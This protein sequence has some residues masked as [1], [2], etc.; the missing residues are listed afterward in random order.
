MS[1]DTRDLWLRGGLV[2][3]GAGN[4]AV[5][6]WARVAPR[7]FY[8]HFPGAGHHWVSAVG[9]YDGHLLTDFGAAL[10]ALGVVL[11]AAAVI[12]ERRL[13]QIALW[14][15][16]VFAV[17]HFAY[18]LSALDRLSFGDNIANLGEL[19]FAVVLPIVLLL[20]VRGP[21][22][23][24]TRANVPPAEAN[25]RI[26]PA[27]A[28]GVFRRSLYLAMRKRYGK[29]MTPVRVMAHHPT[30]CV[31]YVAMEVAAERAHGVDERL[32][33]L[34]TIKA[35][36]LAGCEFCLDIGSA[37]GRRCGISDDELAELGAYRDSRLL[38]PVDKLVIEYADHVTRTPV[39]VPDE[40]FARLREHFDER[41]LVELTSAIA[42]E[43][44]RARFNGAFKIG[45]DGF[46]QGAYCVPPERAIASTATTVA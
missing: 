6:V 30:I 23:V 17:P 31:G 42:L 45:A 36:M 7:N 20:L 26:A 2:L 14:A 1:R 43:N 18:H 39:D 3:L 22:L 27:P 38:S 25:A 46:S 19:G 33:E 29:V 16:L 12:L 4:A 40:L 28:R 24:S 13:V 21:V 41:Q 34:A 10:L 35:A 44:Y 5:G 32:K 37:I 8:D 11:L 15:S 9:P